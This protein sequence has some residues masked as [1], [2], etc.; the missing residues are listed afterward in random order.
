MACVRYATG[1]TA[2]VVPSL[3]AMTAQNRSKLSY[4]AGYA[5]RHP[6]RIAAYARRRGR[7]FWLGLRTHDHLSYY[8]AVMR[9]DASRSHAGAVGS[10]TRES[11]LKIGQLQFDYLL[12]HGLKP[13]MQ[14]LEIGCGNLRRAGCSSTTWMPGTTTA[15]TS[16]PRSCSRRRTRSPSSACSGSCRT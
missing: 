7:D 8:R 4:K 6:G 3:D 5:I 9:S 12:G 14:M 11:W 10:K 1:T 2:L 16:R 15:S 13:G